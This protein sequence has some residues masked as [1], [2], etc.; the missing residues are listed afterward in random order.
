MSGDFI[1]M[2]AKDSSAMAFSAS[3]TASV[4]H[5]TSEASENDR[6]LGLAVREARH[7]RRLPLKL[8]ADGAN[9]SVGLLSQI[10]RGISSPSVRALRS[11]CSVLDLPVHAL[12]GGTQAAVEQEARRIVRVNQRRSVNFGS[13]GIVKE[14]LTAHD[15]GALQI[16]EIVL[17]PTGESGG[18]PYNHE[19]EEGGVVLEGHLELYIDGSVYRLGEGDAFCFESTLPHKFRN[20]ANG[21][22]RVLWITTPPVW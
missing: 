20:L 13:K 2:T 10:E 16:M 1:L 3:Q 6:T 4:P 8:V 9:I 11:I 19:G 5:G 21:P 22:T 7:A 18:E 12:F 15:K 14:F 17:E